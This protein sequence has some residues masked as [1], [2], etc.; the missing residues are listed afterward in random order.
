MLQVGRVVRAVFTD[1]SYLVD[2]VV[3]IAEND[4]LNLLMLHSY[5][6]GRVF[7]LP[8]RVEFTDVL[9]LV[10]MVVHVADT[11]KINQF[12]HQY[13]VATWWI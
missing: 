3:R 4:D 13:F 8:R 5:L 6:F 10:G 11:E 12:F 7:M 2:T 1:V 9:Y